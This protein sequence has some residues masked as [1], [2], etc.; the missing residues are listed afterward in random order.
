MNLD[1]VADWLPI[2]SYLR[3]GLY[4]RLRHFSLHLKASHVVTVLTLEHSSETLLWSVCSW[5]GREC[6]NGGQ[7]TSVPT[8][9]V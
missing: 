6:A 9:A 1:G 2:Y 7:T 4:H 8:G 3:F 5:L